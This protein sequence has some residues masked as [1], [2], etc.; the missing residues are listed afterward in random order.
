MSAG[1]HL[2]GQQF[3]VETLRNAWANDFDETRVHQ[4][5]DS[6]V[7][8]QERVGRVRDSIAKEG[9]REPIELAAPNPDEP[10]YQLLRGHHRAAAALQLGLKHVPAVV[11]QPEETESGYHD[12][13]TVD[14]EKHN[15]KIRSV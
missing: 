3:P 1:H 2:S 11:H 12:Y 6:G 14:W 13:P 8:D 4:L 7:L 5:N 15:P 10:D 9:M